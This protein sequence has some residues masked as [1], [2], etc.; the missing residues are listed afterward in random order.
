MERARER[1][2]VAIDVAEA[3]RAVSLVRALAPS[4]RYFKVGLELHNALGPR[5][6]ELIYGEGGRVLLDLKYHDIPSMVGRAAAVVT[7]L[8]VWGFT[9]HS[10]GGYA[11]MKAALDAATER[12]QVLGIPRPKVIGLTLLTHIDQAM[13]NGELNFP[14]DLQDRVVY[15]AGRA[16]IAGLDGAVASPREVEALRQA[17]GPGFTIITPGIRPSWSEDRADQRRVMTPVEALRAGADCLVVGRPITTAP[18]PVEAAH[19]ILLEMEEV[20]G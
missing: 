2:I 16:K 20:L 7:G 11:M 3:D 8:G 17:V 5:I 12:S 14:G 9:V 13:L 18:D 19:R 10:L 15:L 1:L 6:L 4:V